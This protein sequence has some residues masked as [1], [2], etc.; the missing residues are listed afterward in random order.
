[1]NR[2]R[3]ADDDIHPWYRQFWP[4]FLIALPA[5][6]VVIS[7]HLIYTAYNH[8]DDLVVDEYYKVGLAINQQLD[9]QEKA[10]ALG[11]AARL[12]L[13]PGQVT[14]HVSEGAITDTS[15]ELVLSH[16][17]E[18]DRDF[19]VNLQRVGPGVYNSALPT[20]VAERWHWILRDGAEG[21]WR[22]DGVIG[23]AD[24]LQ[25]GVQDTP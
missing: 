16:P 1:M 7:M 24:L 14:V 12:M 18:S 25:Q 6:V 17:I 22:L 2:P 15:L 19:T 9:R 4:W 8:A 3:L 23:A 21:A 10:R 5:S 11:I 20:P 13:T